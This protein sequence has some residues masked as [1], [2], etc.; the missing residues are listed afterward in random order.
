MVVVDA[1]GSTIVV[2]VGTVVVVVVV[3]GMMLGSMVVVVT[4]GAAV[5]VVVVVAVVTV[6]GT[7]A[8]V[9]VE[10][11]TSPAIRG[12]G[13]VDAG[14]A[15]PSG[16]GVSGTDGKRSAKVVG[17]QAAWAGATATRD[18]KRAQAKKSVVARVLKVLQTTRSGASFKTEG[19]GGSRAVQPLVSEA[20]PSL[21]PGSRQS[22]S[23]RSQW[24]ERGLIRGRGRSRAFSEREGSRSRRLRL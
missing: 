21:P 4:A 11:G 5:V 14:G 1:F 18:T 15:V 2:V 13:G 7:E 23:N 19:G 3:A 6:V 20:G 22:P 24:S 16:I 9:V 12:A 10:V 17:R 8:V